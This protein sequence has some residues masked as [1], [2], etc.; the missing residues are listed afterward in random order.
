MGVR[1][2]KEGVKKKFARWFQQV[3]VGARL[4]R[5]RDEWALQVHHVIVLRGQASLQ[6][7]NLY[8]SPP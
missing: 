1:W 5:E 7:T 6:Q 4:A 8:P 3:S 2:R